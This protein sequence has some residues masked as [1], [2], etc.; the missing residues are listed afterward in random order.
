MPKLSNDIEMKGVIKAAYLLLFFCMFIF[1]GI[2]LPIMS[3]PLFFFP[4]PNY[5]ELICN[6]ILPEVERDLETG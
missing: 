6:V 4:F 3:F 1:S 5:Q 2:F